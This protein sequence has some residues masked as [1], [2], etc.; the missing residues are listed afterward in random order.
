MRTVKFTQMK[1]DAVGR[2]QAALSCELTMFTDKTIT[3]PELLEAEIVRQT[4]VWRGA[5]EAMLGINAIAAPIY[6]KNNAAVAV[7]GAIRFLPPEPDY[8]LCQAPR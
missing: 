7:G 3:R 5:K 6:D 1:S 2:R 8:K 4:R